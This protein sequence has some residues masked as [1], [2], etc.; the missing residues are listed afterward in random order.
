MP[1]QEC[2]TIRRIR[3]LEIPPR[4]WLAHRAATRCAVRPK[5]PAPA[6]PR[7]GRAERRRRSARAGGDLTAQQTLYGGR[8]PRIRDVEILEVR[9]P[10]QHDAEEMK[11]R[12]RARRSIAGL[13]GIASA[14]GNE[15]GKCFHCAGHH[16][17]DHEQ[18]GRGVDRRNRSEILLRIVTERLVD[19]RVKANHCGRRQDH[20]RPVCRA[21]LQDIQHHTAAR[22]GTVLD[23]GRRRIRLHLLRNESRHD[24]GG[25]ARRKANHDARRRLRWLR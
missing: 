23:D 10:R 17:T 2:Q 13:I 8:R 6:A 12:T 14:P 20:G 22:T 9:R 24:I 15:I 7:I 11:R 25:A 4:R 18:H 1:G 16:R 19:V 5:M 3:A 21:V